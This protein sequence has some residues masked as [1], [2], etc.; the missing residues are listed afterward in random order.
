MRKVGP[1]VPF[2]CISSCRTIGVIGVRYKYVFFFSLKECNHEVASE[3]SP[4]FLYF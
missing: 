1:H 2:L 4:Q 3:M